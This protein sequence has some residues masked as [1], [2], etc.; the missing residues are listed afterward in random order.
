[1]VL[2]LTTGLG[3]YRPRRLALGDPIQVL[4]ELGIEKGARSGHLHD[5]G[6]LATGPAGDV[7][8]RKRAD[9]TRSIETSLARDEDAM[10][11]L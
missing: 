11:R 2:N 5:L 1:M 3:L 6:T 4:E 7:V 10:P 9:D 8:D